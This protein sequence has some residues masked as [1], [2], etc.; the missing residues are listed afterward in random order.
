MSGYSLAW[1][2]VGLAGLGGLFGLYMLLRQYSRRFPLAL[3]VCVL[4]AVLFVPA[5]VPNYEGQWA[6]AFVVAIFEGFFQLEGR[7]GQALQILTAALLFGLVLVSGVAW[8]LTIRRR[9]LAQTG[10]NP[11]TV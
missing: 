8:L 7:P 11:P 6:P 9:R 1:W 2:L 3:L 5:P 10:K 4:A